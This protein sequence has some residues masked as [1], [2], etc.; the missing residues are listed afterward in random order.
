M[1]SL[2]TTAPGSPPLEQRSFQRRMLETARV[3]A[4]RGEKCARVLTQTA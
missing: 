4:G 3:S 1:S 2:A